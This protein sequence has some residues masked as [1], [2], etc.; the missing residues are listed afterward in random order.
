MGLEQ[1]DSDLKEAR[2]KVNEGLLAMVKGYGG[3]SGVVNLAERLPYQSMSHVDR[4]RYWDDHVHFTKDGYDVVAET[5][6][7]ALKAI[8]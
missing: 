2:L 8:L 3:K 7:D 1:K 4:K 5:V 6:F